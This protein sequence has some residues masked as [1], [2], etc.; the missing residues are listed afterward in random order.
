MEKVYA[1]ILARHAD[2][3]EAVDALMAHLKRRGRMKLL[4]HILRELKALLHTKTQRAGVLEVAH[5][6]ERAQ[7]EQEAAREGATYATVQVRPE[8]LRG[9]RVRSHGTLVDRSGKRS[10]VDLYQN[11]VR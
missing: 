4:P 3:K 2:S 10:L 7:A 11:I 8:L 6:A 1:D 5:E 9:W